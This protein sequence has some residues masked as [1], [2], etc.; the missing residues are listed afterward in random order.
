MNSSI[1]GRLKFYEIDFTSGTAVFSVRPIGAS[2]SAISSAGLNEPINNAVDSAGN[3]EFYVFTNA[4][5]FGSA[6]SVEDTYF[7]AF[8]STT[9]KDEVFASIPGSGGGGSSVKNIELV[10]RVGYFRQYYVIYKTTCLNNLAN[11]YIR[12][13]IVDMNTKT[14]S[15]PVTLTAATNNEGMAISQSPCGQTY[16]WLF[17][18]KYNSG[19][20]AFYR[21]L[22]DGTGISAPV[23]ITTVLIPGN[24][25]GGQGDLEISPQG[26]CLAYA[27]MATVS[28]NQ[29]VVLFDL[30]LSAGS[31]SSSRWINAPS[32]YIYGLEFSLNGK[33]LYL[34]QTGSS[35]TTNK[36]FNVAVISGDYHI[37]PSDMISAPLSSG[38]IN[39]EMGFDNNLYFNSSNYNTHYYYISNSNADAASN[40]INQSPVN[41]FGPAGA[42]TH[43]FPDQVDGPISAAPPDGLSFLSSFDHCSNTYLFIPTEYPAASFL[44][45]FGDGT[46]SS[47]SSPTHV[48]DPGS[49]NVTLIAS[50]I[51]P[52]SSSQVVIVGEY[53]DSALILPNVFTPN[54]D[55]ENDELIFSGFNACVSYELTIYNRWGQVVFSTNSP[56]SV[57]WNGKN[58]A[59]DE[60][61]AGTYF[62]LLKPLNPEGNHQVIKGFVSLV[63]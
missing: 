15:A 49:F 40:I 9:G 16:R 8:D 45:N 57:F 33:R 2:I 41:S 61:V 53:A 7:V 31:L 59:K 37:V 60:I 34:S 1:P 27:D 63:Q 56:E 50:G 21:C 23:L 6:S 54:N 3:V 22:I 51:C 55:G 47:L 58:G 32:G 48:F 5:N 29:D 24:A 10:E 19:N 38:L 13:V 43:S 62:Y 46:S 20:I 44:W 35:A 12:Y 26:N 42:V 28:I 36:L 25:S 17:F 52:D 14:I 11:D 18:T 4:T 30:D 39:M